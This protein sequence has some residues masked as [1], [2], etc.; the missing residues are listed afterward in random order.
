M[1][2]IG[3]GGHC[4][5]ATGDVPAV[6]EQPVVLAR[7]LLDVAPGAVVTVVFQRRG[8]GARPHVQTAQKQCS[9]VVVFTGTHLDEV[10][11]ETVHGDHGGTAGTAEIADLGM[12][13][14]FPV[15]QGADGFGDHEVEVGVALAVAM[16]AHV[17]WHA[18]HVGGEIGAVI[19][20]EA[21]QEV[22]VGLACAAV[23][24][25]HH[26]GHQFQHIPGAQNGA[27]FDLFLADQ[28]LGGT[29]G[30]ADQVQAASGDLDFFQRRL[31]LGLGEHWR[32]Q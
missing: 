25:H 2:V 24:G 11:V 29:G 26:A 3:H 22:L 16:G 1:V 6:L 18:V 10:V 30:L 4:R 28:A 13:G 14:A 7:V 21:P 32:P 5:L 27:Q 23:L 8:G 9:I 19:Q 12:I 31:L 20:V 15:S 17:D